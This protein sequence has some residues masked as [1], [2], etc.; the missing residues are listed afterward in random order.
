[1]TSCLL[2]AL[3][4]SG[5]AAFASTAHGVILLNN[6][7]SVP[8]ISVLAD[9]DRSFRVHD[10]IFHVLTYTATAN[11]P[12]SNVSIT[13]FVAAN[14]LDGV[15]FDLVGGF[16]DLPNDTLISDMGFHYTVEVAPEFIARG[17]RIVDTGLAFN[18]AATGPGSFSRVDETI[19]DPF[20]QPGLNII[21]NRQVFAVAGPPPISQLQDYQ[22]LPGTA[23]YTMLEINKDIQFYAFGPNGTATASFVRQSFSQ[24]PTP[25][26]AAL[27]GLA[28]LIVA[29]RRRR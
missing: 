28:G 6:G 27:L 25:G 14:P 26:G 22:L 18:G 17:F 9:Q 11:L 10:K 19:I 20:G 16:G 8:L 3:A 1:M 7:D 24:I 13:A 21:G 15:G 5:F 2:R 29:H 4:V 23:G 12:A